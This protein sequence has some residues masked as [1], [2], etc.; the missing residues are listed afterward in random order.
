ML[1]CHKPSIS[2]KH[3]I[4]KV[5]Y[6]RYTPVLV[7][8]CCCNKWLYIQWFKTIADLLFYSPVG[9]KSD[10]GLTGGGA[11]QPSLWRLRGDLFLAL[12]QLL[13]APATLGLQPL[14]FKA[15][16]ASPQSLALAPLPFSSS[17]DNA[18]QPPHHKILNLITP[19]KSS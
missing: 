7:F 19:A 1:D 2:K 10:V 9:Q 12:F 14:P 6:T 17:P 16:N 8:Y 5:Q 18:G 3:N 11:W 4:C 13:K 15:S